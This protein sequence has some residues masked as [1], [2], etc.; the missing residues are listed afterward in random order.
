MDHAGRT[1]LVTGGTGH[2]GGA[3]A[4]HLLADGWRVRALVRD[5]AKPAAIAL[6]DA[7]AEL[8]VGDLLDP[9]SLA[10]AASGAYGV[11]SVQTPV[12]VDAG[13]EVTEGVNL[14][15]AAQDAGV[16]H[17][18]YSSVR[19][20]DEPGDVAYAMSKHRIEE[21]LASSG[22]A[23]TVWRPVTFMENFV[24]QRDEIMAGRLVG[25][26]PPDA[27]KQMIAVDDIGRFV[28]LAFSDPERFTG[29]TMEIE[30]DE[31]SWGEVAATFARM[32][33]RPVEYVE[34]DAA[35]PAMASKRKADLP[36]L[37]ALIPDLMTL[38]GWI[39]SLGWI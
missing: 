7:G 26:Q 16:S 34:S 4:R 12:G 28:A 25:P 15:K 13:D 39:R 35:F 11:Y 22:L 31:M 2:Q 27:L 24:R 5:P 23:V 10:E 14:A 37:K 29:V 6:R 21:Y 3:A 36:A 32:L 20:A 30:S 9:A 8:V 18:V 1:V 38:E 17:F 33:G 19:G